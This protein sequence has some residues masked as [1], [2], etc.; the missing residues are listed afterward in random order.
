MSAQI[1]TQ[2]KLYPCVASFPIKEEF[3]TKEE[4]IKIAK[5]VALKQFLV[6]VIGRGGD[7][8]R[9]VPLA[10]AR[11]GIARSRGDGQHQTTSQKIYHISVRSYGPAGMKTWRIILDNGKQYHNHELET[12]LHG[13]HVARKLTSD[14]LD[15]VL[16]MHNAE[17][18]TRQIHSALPKAFPV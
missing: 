8:N 7:K 2:T 4:A 11:Y 9:K 10:C 17:C 16:S 3:A 6:L 12:N 1:A 15:L 5:D 14:Q 18:F 13:Y